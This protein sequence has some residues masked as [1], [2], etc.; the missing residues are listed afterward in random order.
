MACD[1]RLVDSRHRPEDSA[2]LLALRELTSEVIA[3]GRRALVFSQFV[4]LLT[5][6]RRDL[7]ALGIGYSYL[8]GRTRNRQSVIDGFVEGNDPLFLLSL[9]AGGTGIN[10]AAADVVIHLDP[11]WNPAVEDQATDRA[12]RI[13]QTRTVSVYRIVAAG[14]IEEAIM[15]IKQRK[16]TL[17]TAVIEED[18]LER[19]PLTA[20]EVDELLQFAD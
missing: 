14:T 6:V 8:D 11:W 3:S 17:A 19:A 12:H 4:E 18:S 5:L 1:P 10:L 20:D 15:R 16:R 2:K 9:R 7:D 13:G